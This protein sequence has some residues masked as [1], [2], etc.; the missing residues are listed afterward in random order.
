MKR[1][2]IIFI[3]LITCVIPLAG[4]AEKKYTFVVGFKG[5]TYEK[6]AHSLNDLKALSFK[7]INTHGSDEIIRKVNTGKADFGISQLD[8][9]LDLYNNEKKRVKNVQFLLPLYAEE[10][11]LLAEKSINS[12][13]DL[14]GKE[15][16][17]GALHSGTAGTALII[18]KEL[19]IKK[20][21]FG[22]FRYMDA[23]KGIENLKKEEISAV[24]IVSG[25]PIATLEKL[26]N[27]FSNKFHLVNLGDDIYKKLS[28]NLYHYRKGLIP[29]GSY[30]WLANDVKTVSIVS[31]IVVNKN[32][33]GKKISKL[34]KTIFSNKNKLQ[35]KHIKWKELSKDTIKWYLAGRTDRFHP[36][37]V[38]T[39]M[40]LVK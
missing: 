12:I 3:I 26:R 9:L 25:A 28:K 5:G 8:V 14:S 7:I 32:I 37:A 36:A 18:M 6:F 19:G 20:S 11:H 40:P 29:G 4:F 33:P 23:A 10:V 31:S 27:D 13:Y 22:K 34:I 2:F 39:L 38:K 15:I 24:F 17:M 16:S 35:R 21:I 30:K 1:N